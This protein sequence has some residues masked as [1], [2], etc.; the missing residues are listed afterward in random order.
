MKFGLYGYAWKIF[1]IIAALP[2]VWLSACQGPSSSTTPPALSATPTSPTSA[3]TTPI[4]SATSPFPSGVTPTGTVSSPVPTANSLAALQQNKHLSV[5]LTTVTTF[6]AGGGN[7]TFPT[8]FSVPPVPI[9][10]TGV[11][12]SGHLEEAGAGEDI[13]DLVSGS[14]SPDGLTVASL[15]YS[16]QI[17]RPALQTGNFFR[18]TLAGLPIASLVNGAAVGLGAFNQSGAGLQALVTKVEYLDGP[19][20]N[21]QIAST[22][23]FVSIDW[24]ASGAQQPNLKL[25]FTN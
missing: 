24:T 2:L 6:L 8:V 25:A 9:A 4:I 1:L 14:V 17:M 12:F 7:I 18:V 19:L 11:S 13:T 10:W 23:S 15:V 16:R 21:G 5:T 3:S 20:N 22:S